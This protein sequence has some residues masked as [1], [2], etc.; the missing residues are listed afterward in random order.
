MADN[1]VGPASR[2]RAMA[3][4]VNVLIEQPGR[5][6]AKVMH[7]SGAEVSRWREHIQTIRP[8]AATTIPVTNAATHENSRK[9]SSTR[10]MAGALTRFLRRCHA[11][12]CS[13]STSDEM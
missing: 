7:V 2:P 4:S 11:V 13:V 5:L 3:I 6:G 9:S 8:A 1:E 12:V 10:L